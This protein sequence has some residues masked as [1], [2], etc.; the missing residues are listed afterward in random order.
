MAPNS[1]EEVPQWA[2]RLISEHKVT[3]FSKTYCPYC[4]AAIAALKSINAPD[5]VRNTQPSIAVIF[6]VYMH[7]TSAEE[8]LSIDSVCCGL[9]HVEQIEDNPHCA[10]IQDYMLK[11]T[12]ARSVPRVFINGKFF[13]DGSATVAAVK[14]GELQKALDAQH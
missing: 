4:Q 9:Q 3:V 7:L 11:K 6:E 8:A 2:D 10:A 12:G 5:M 1:A 13:G 14:N